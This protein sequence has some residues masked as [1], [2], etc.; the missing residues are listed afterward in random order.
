MTRIP[1]GPVG[2]CAIGLTSLMLAGCGV[3][4]GQISLSL[5]SAVLSRMPIE[6]VLPEFLETPP[7]AE[8]EVSG[9]VQNCIE[10]LTATPVGQKQATLN[11]CAWDPR[12]TDA[13]ITRIELTAAIA[14]ILEQERPVENQYQA[15]RLRNRKVVLITQSVFAVCQKQTIPSRNQPL[16]LTQKR[17]SP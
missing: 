9:A 2:F 1:T 16:M 11:R 3:T 5:G 10:T 12:L 13:E 15:A 4:A 17:S 7:Q 14:A 8:S 6:K